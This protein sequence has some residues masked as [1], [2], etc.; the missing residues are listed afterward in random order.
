MSEAGFMNQD[1]MVDLPPEVVSRVLASMDSYVEQITKKD[2][3]C[4]ATLPT[5]GA[6]LEAYSHDGGWPLDGLPGLWWLYIHCPEC[7][8][9]WALWKLGVA[10]EGKA[11]NEKMEEVNA[12]LEEGTATISYTLTDTQRL[13]RLL[14]TARGRLEYLTEHGGGTP[15]EAV[16]IR[17]LKKVLSWDKCCGDCELL[18][19]P[20]ACSCC[21]DGTGWPCH[22]DGHGQHVHPGMGVCVDYKGARK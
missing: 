10:R 1:T 21:R 15:R 8:Y 2:C 9:D 14:S 13:D 18:G 5:G 16:E 11:T 6:N 7:G 17:I 22:A 20:I 4:G 19:E 12:L 3:I